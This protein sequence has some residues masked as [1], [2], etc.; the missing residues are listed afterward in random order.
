MCKFY[1][2]INIFFVNITIISILLSIF[3]FIGGTIF[4][5]ITIFTNNT[6]IINVY[7]ILRYIFLF[8]A[9]SISYLIFYDEIEELAN[10]RLEE[11]NKKD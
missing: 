5:T 1:K 2:R 11:L 4:V 6:Q 9:S 7:D 10:Q 8:L 3:I